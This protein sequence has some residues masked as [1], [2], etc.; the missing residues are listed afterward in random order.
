MNIRKFKWVYPVNRPFL[1]RAAV[2]FDVALTL[3]TTGCTS[4]AQRTEPAPSSF[5]FSGVTPPTP[6][7]LLAYAQNPPVMVAMARAETALTQECMTQFGYE[8]KPEMDFDKYAESFLVSD[9]RLYGITDPVVAKVYGYLPAPGN[10][11]IPNA[12]AAL[13]GPNFDLVLIGVD[14]GEAPTPEVLSKSPGTLGGIEIP[15]GGCLGDARLK[16]TGNVSGNALDSETLGQD[17]HIQAWR[18]AM[19]DE[20]LAAAKNAWA[21]CMAKGGYTGIDPIGGPEKL[22]GLGEDGTINP[23]SDSEVKQALVDIECKRT[24]D[25]VKTA[26]AVHV[27]YALRA[28]NENQLALEDSKNFFDNALENANDVIANG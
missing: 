23:A 28:I 6:D 9:A 5:A 11:A 8:F 24:T 21:R 22:S 4:D 1:R 13:A 16:V 12:N 25:W 18:A 20:K 2:V 17:L 7:P 3:T 19:Q 14:N 27:D 15:A 10:S 26:N